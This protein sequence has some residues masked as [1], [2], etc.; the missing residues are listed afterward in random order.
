M[1]SIKNALLHERFMPTAGELVEFISGGK[2][3][4][5]IQEWQLVL[6]AS[7]SGAEKATELLAYASMRCRTALQAIGGL[8]A[9][10]LTESD[11]Q[12]TNL[13]K[14]F[15]TVYCQCSDKDAKALP[16]SESI[17]TQNRQEEKEDSIPMDYYL[18]LV[19]CTTLLR[20]KVSI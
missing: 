11:F 13:Q 12:R 1:A 6:S 7:R 17:P 16:Q 20:A 3:A 4:K 9:V 15:T 19:R 8:R 14:Q 18:L 2:E 5:A 10:G